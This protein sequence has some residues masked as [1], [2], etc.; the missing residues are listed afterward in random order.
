[1]SVSRNDPCPCGSGRKYKKCCMGQEQNAATQQMLQKR[2]R[3]EQTARDRK[4]EDVEFNRYVVALEELT[5]RAND[6]IRSE[7]WAEAETC[8]RQ[9]KEKFSEEIDGDQRF[10][11]YYKARGDFARAKTHA[12]ATL[13]MVESREGFD[14]EFPAELKKDIA[15]FEERIQ[16]DHPEI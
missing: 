8:C 2:A 14:P 16:A 13:A 6:L 4:A 5:N 1:M 3:D 15:D 7:Q 10:Y 12:Q 11:E 9:L